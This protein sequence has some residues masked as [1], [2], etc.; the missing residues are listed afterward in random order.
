M[1]ADSSLSDST[2]AHCAV[3]RALYHLTL[4]TTRGFTVALSHFYVL[5]A[6]SLQHQAIY[7]LLLLHYVCVDDELLF[8]LLLCHHSL[9]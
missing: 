1:R 9:V 6:S 5:R 7:P 3:H 8:I 2:A 4:H